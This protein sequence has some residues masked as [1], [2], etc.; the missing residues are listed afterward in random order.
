MPLNYGGYRSKKKKCGILCHFCAINCGIPE[1]YNMICSLKADPGWFRA[2]HYHCFSIISI[3]TYSEWVPVL[4][5]MA[6]PEMPEDTTKAV[7]P[8]TS[9]P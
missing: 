9:V 7:P 8:R 3:T 4:M 1:Y 6:Q 5:G 2:S